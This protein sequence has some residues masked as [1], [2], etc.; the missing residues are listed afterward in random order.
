MCQWIIMCE[1]LCSDTIKDTW[2]AGRR[3]AERKH[4]FVDNTELFASRVHWQEI[5]IILQQTLIVCCCNCWALTL[6]SVCLNTEWAIGIWHSWLKHF[7]CWWKAVKIWF[8]SHGYLMWNCMFTW[9]SGLQ[10]LN[11]CIWGTISDILIK[12]DVYVVWIL[13]YKVWKFGSNPYYRG[14]NTAFFSKGLF[15]YW[16]TLYILSLIRYSGILHTS[17]QYLL[18]IATSWLCSMCRH[19]AE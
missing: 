17:I 19:C 11:C 7:N 12:F 3:N 5:C 14:W 4:R 13:T 10:S 2:K 18:Q 16:R 9:K 15:C 1:I 8:V 6:K